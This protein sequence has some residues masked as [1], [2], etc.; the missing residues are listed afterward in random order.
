MRVKEYKIKLKTK[1]RN[2]SK[3]TMRNTRKG[4]TSLKLKEGGRYN[5]LEWIHYLNSK[6]KISFHYK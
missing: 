3:N 4:N 6:I 5:H 2:I 1:S